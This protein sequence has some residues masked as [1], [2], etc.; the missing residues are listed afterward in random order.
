MTGKK[1]RTVYRKSTDLMIRWLESNAIESTGPNPSIRGMRKR[2]W[3]DSALL[4]KCGTYLY[5]IDRVDDGREI[6]NGD[7]DVERRRR[8]GHRS[9]RA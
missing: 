3:G 1:G 8:G 2:Y 6:F 9:K 5:L 7:S 4:V